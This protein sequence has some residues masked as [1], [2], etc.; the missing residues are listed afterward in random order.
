MTKEDDVHFLK[1]AI[2]IGKQAGAQ[3][4]FGA[5]VVKDGEVIASDYSHVHENNDPTAHAETSAI[6]QAAQELGDFSLEGCTLYVSHAPCLMCF[7]S[8]AWAH[9][10]RIAY[11]IPRSEV[12]NF[13]YEFEGVN[14]QEL[15]LRLTR[16]PMTVEM[17]PI[18]I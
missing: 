13:T 11:A 2:K 14:L 7:S 5:L 9:I 1:Q 3:H 12:H 16:R 8:A 6:R 15:A 18:K 17:I 10:D 4:D